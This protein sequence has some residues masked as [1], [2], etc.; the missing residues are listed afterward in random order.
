MAM[1]LRTLRTVL[2]L[3]LLDKLGIPAVFGD[4][5]PHCVAI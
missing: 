1:I 3:S 5:F 4:F 2:R